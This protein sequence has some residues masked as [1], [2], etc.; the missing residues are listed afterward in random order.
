MIFVFRINYDFY[1]SRKTKIR[2]YFFIKKYFIK[3]NEN[4]VFRK[5]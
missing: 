2:P 4:S 1:F 5:L 3:E